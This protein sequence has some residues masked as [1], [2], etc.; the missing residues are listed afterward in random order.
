VHQNC[1][2]LKTALNA[3]IDQVN[4]QTDEHNINQILTTDGQKSEL[5]KKVV[6]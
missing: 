2:A 1:L 3:N 6:M 5:T 4:E